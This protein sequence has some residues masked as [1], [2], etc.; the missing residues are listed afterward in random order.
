MVEAPQGSQLIVFPPG[1][2]TTHPSESHGVRVV[3]D[4]HAPVVNLK[5][6]DFFYNYPYDYRK[7]TQLLRDRY[8]DFVGN[9]EYHKIRKR[10][11]NNPVF[12]RKRILNPESP[13]SASIMLFSRAI[14]HEFDKH[15][16]KRLEE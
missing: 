15:Y 5:E 4:P 6:E 7:L 10:F 12:S 2:T 16:T 14:V 13:R 8:T 9:N 3:D 11:D 1:S